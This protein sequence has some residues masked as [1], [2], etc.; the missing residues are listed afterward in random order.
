MQASALTLLTAVTSNHIMFVFDR[1]HHGIGNS[2]DL[3]GS[4]LRFNRS[5]ADAGRNN[6]STPGNAGENAAEILG[7]R[8]QGVC[9]KPR[10]DDCELVPA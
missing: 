8:R 5:P 6:H 3:I 2:N 4:L 10:A 7:S 9:V 1:I